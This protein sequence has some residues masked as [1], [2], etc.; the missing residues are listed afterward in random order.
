MLPGLPR[1]DALTKLTQIQF[2]GY[3]HNLYAGDGEIYDMHNMTGDFAPV[4]SPREPR[5]LIK[6]LSKPNGV[7]AKDGLM[8]VD[9]ADVYY[10]GVKVGTATDSPKTFGELGAYIVILPDKKYYNILT[11]VFGSIEASASSVTGGVTFSNGALYGVETNANTLVAASVDFNAY[12]KAGDAITISGCTVH[13]ENN[14]TPIVREISS[15]GHTLSFYANVFTLDGT[16]GSP[17]AYTEPGAITFE[18]N[19]PAL[20]FI[21]S[22][23][24]RLWGCKGDE[25]FASKMGDIFNWNVFDGLASDSWTVPVGSEGDFTGCVSY[26][27]YPMFFKDGAIYKVLGTEPS[28]FETSASFSSGV[29]DGS[30]R[31]LTAAGDML[32]YLS[33]NGV[34]SYTGSMPV[35]RY[36]MFGGVLYTDGVS[37]SDRRKYYISMLDEGA[38]PHLFVFDTERG[39]WHRED[40]ARP[41]GFAYHDS[42]LYMLCDDGC[43]WTIGNIMNPPAEVL[44]TESV[45]WSVEFA[46]FSEGA[47]EKKGVTKFYM[48]LEMDEGATAELL[49]RYDSAGEWLRIWRRSADSELSYPLLP[50]RS[51]TVPIIPRRADHF[52]LRLT[53][54]GGCKIYGMTRELYLGSTQRSLRGRH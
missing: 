27:G 37:G 1:G 44:E 11:G 52:R 10:K 36:E 30:G 50:K 29:Q 33:R 5:L 2:G 22:N 14:K 17:V 4:L 53:G 15:D 12:F 46:D 45:E 13:P 42:N 7:F 25:I 6:E 51:F 19:M 43:L 9:G 54:E 24:N 16:A 3:N 34:M 38:S 35:R 31:S 26:I 40:D 41:I 32:F 21:C 20:D 49:I 8:W 48:R 47:P 18:R 28:N 39:L 23:E